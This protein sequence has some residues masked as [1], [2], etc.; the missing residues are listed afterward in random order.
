VP[1]WTAIVGIVTAGVVGP[2][3]NWL[4][5]RRRFSHERKLKSADDLR[6]LIDQVEVALDQLGAACAE[7]RQRVVPY[8]GDPERVGPSLHKAEDAYQNARAVIARLSMRPHAGDD[9]VRQAKGAADHFLEANK[10]VRTAVVIASMG[11]QA[12]MELKTS[13]LSGLGEVGGAIERGYSATHDYEE[14]ARAAV[15]KLL[16]SPASKP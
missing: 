7:M 6:E 15:V 12:P 13:G 14:S 3:G 1:D 4:A 9:L 8:G 2:V 5:D 16:G 10:L 11:E